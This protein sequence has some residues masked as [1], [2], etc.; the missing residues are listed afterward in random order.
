TGEIAQGAGQRRVR[1]LWPLVPVLQPVDAGA[2]YGGDVVQAVVGLPGAVVNG[3][4][5][6][7]LHMRSCFGKCRR[8]GTAWPLPTVRLAS[9]ARQV[10]RWALSMAV[11]GA[12]PRASRAARVE[13]MVQPEPW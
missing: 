3:V 1:A 7:C 12:S 8:R 10:M 13:A 4:N 6:A 2:E 11:M 5:T 9:S